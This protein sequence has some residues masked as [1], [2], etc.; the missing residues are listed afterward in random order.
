MAVLAGVSTPLACGSLRST[1]T[2]MEAFRLRSLVARCTQRER[3]GRRFDSARLSL[4]AL[5]ANG[6]GESRRRV[7]IRSVM[8]RAASAL[9]R[10]RARG[11]GLR[12]SWAASAQTSVASDE[13]CR[14]RLTRTIAIRI[15][16]RFPALVP[17]ETRVIYSA[18]VRKRWRNQ[19]SVRARSSVG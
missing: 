19:V 3:L 1:R 5:N 13:R 12:K 9:I 16:A 14:K 4:A 8:G 2:V 6:C 18:A 11:Q 10:L 7:L 17:D 15:I